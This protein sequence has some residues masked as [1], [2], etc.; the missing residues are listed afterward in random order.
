[1]WKLKEPIRTPQ[2]V[3]A[4]CLW[5]DYIV[6]NNA[7]KSINPRLALLQDCKSCAGGCQPFS[8]QELDLTEKELEKVQGELD[9]F[10]K[11]IMA[12]LR[13]REA[14]KDCTDC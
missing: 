1:M 14:Y 10:Q 5:L 12:V 7:N 13:E 8:Y 2:G 4:N 6:I 11:A 3:E 9:A